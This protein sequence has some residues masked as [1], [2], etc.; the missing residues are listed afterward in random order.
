MNPPEDA[1]RDASEARPSAAELMD[2]AEAWRPWRG[3]GAH[4][5]WAAY[6]LFKARDGAP[7]G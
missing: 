1:S 3:A 5:L 2:L 4:V 7:L 6:R